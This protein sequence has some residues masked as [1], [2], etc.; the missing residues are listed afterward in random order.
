VAS[1]GWAPSTLWGL[2]TPQPPPQRLF[3]P[4]LPLPLQ[5]LSRG[6]CGTWQTSDATPPWLGLAVK[7]GLIFVFLRGGVITTCERYS[8]YISNVVLCSDAK[9]SILEPDLLTNSSPQL[10]PLARRPPGGPPAPAP[11]GAGGGGVP[12]GG[13]RVGQVAGSS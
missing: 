8:D 9:Y 3:R 11:G 4:G 12:G 7:L 5:C 13:P 2:G 1:R 10:G 6:S